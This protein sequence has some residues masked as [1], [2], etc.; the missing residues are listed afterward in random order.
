MGDLSANRSPQGYYLSWLGYPGG[1][2]YLDPWT[3][4]GE[5]CLDEE[6]VGKWRLR[7]YAAARLRGYAATRLCGCAAARLRCYA[8][9]RP[10][11]VLAWPGLVIAWPGLV[12]AQPLSSVTT[13]HNFAYSE[14]HVVVFCAIVSSV[15]PIVWSSI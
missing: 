3:S 10:G 12:M 4:G 13:K 14:L 7:G 2:T 15:N 11:L 8:V 5:T 9:E 1:G 6:M